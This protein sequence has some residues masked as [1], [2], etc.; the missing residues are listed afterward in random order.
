MT[1]NS[2]SF[3]PHAI[4][5]VVGCALL[6]AFVYRHHSASI[7]KSRNVA[8]IA[9]FSNQWAVASEKLR[10]QKVVNLAVERTFSTQTEAIM[11]YSNSLQAVSVDLQQAEKSADLAAEEARTQMAQQDARIA[12]LE[13]ERVGMTKTL[14]ELSGSISNLET[15]IAQTEQKLQASNAD[16]EVLMAE[17]KRLQAEK[18]DLEER[19]HNL[20]ALRD[21]IHKIRD[22]LS[23]S[24]RLAWLRRGLFGNLKGAEVLQ[25]GFAN[26]AAS[27]ERVSLEVELRRNEPARIVSSQTP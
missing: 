22:E 2:N 3:R 20:A 6:I 27:A 15:Q 16:R 23:I 4:L 1:P 14:G 8:A 10:E 12:E 17:L 25:N 9:H 26:A 13:Q 11:G 19:F 7:E 18:T 21:Q 5:C 24:R